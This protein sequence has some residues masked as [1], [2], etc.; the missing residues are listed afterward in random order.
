VPFF[1]SAGGSELAGWCDTVAMAT[2]GKHTHTQLD[3][4][5]IDFLSRDGG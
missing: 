5:A 2:N 1:S 3:L 4:L